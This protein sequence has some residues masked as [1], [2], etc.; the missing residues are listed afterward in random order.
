MGGG[1]GGPEEM[2]GGNSGWTGI[3][4]ITGTMGFGVG[5]ITLGVLG[6]GGGGG[7]LGVTSIKGGTTIGAIGF[8]FS[9]ISTT[10]PPRHPSGKK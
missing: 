5:G 2:T 9:G 3:L 7:G 10:S 1:T 8:L 6:E 4:G